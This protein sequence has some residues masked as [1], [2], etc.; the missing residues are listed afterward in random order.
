MGTPVRGR[1]TGREGWSSETTSCATR[2]SNKNLKLVSYRGAR[3]K[4]QG[5]QFRYNRPVELAIDRDFHHCQTRTSTTYQDSTS[6]QTNII[7][8][9]PEK[10]VAF[11]GIPSSTNSKVEN[12][13]N[14]QALVSW[15][16][17]WPSTFVKVSTTPTHS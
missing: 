1:N 3:I 13:H 7:M 11:I 16:T 9:P 5:Y 12:A 10:T 6:L 2:S 8:S 15:A 4:T 14:N 17:P